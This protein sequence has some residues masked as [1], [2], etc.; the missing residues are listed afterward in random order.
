M[1]FKD[2]TGIKFNRLTA[3]SHFKIGKATYWICKCE[4]G[5]MK[6][7]E[8]GNLKTGQVKSCGCLRKEVSSK[9]LTGYNMSEKGRFNPRKNGRENLLNWFETHPEEHKELARNAGR[10]GGIKALKDYRNS[11]EGIETSRKN[12]AIWSN[13]EKGK[14]H[15]KRAGKEVGN[16]YGRINGI[17]N[18]SS[19]KLTTNIQRDLNGALEKE[20]IKTRMEWWVNEIRRIIDIAI[21]EIK[22]A[23]EVDGESHKGMFG[24]SKEEKQTDDKLKDQQLQFLGWKVIRFTNKEVKNNLDKCVKIIKSE[25]ENGIS[26]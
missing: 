22:L 23:I 11:K 6:N 17:K 1:E 4:C 8:G 2:L 13:S 5:N 7:V 26:R 3:L 16:K 10:N 20:E 24:Q 19:I 25:V 18:F 12:M 21:P 14:E 15:S 9:I